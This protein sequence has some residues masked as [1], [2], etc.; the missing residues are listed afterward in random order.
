MLQSVSET[1]DPPR[2]P[3]AT[4]RFGPFILDTRRRVLYC[5]AQIVPLSENLF[6]I[7]VL[8]VRA[9]GDVVTKATFFS[10]VW[11]EEHAT[12]A[13]LAQH[14]LMLR[15]ALGERARDRSYIVTVPRKGYRLAVSTELKAG[16]RMKGSCERC[17]ALVSSDGEAYICSYEC[18][19]CPTCAQQ[20]DHTCPNCAGALL[21][22]P[23]RRTGTPNATN[24]VS[25]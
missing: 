2:R 24:G 9:D 17:T 8:L 12:D 18:T 19:F 22:R 5:G 10:E 21:V 15:H 1:V 20:L 16:L 7:L 3:H 4:Y 11:D 14:I 13:N 6:R 23:P 25:R